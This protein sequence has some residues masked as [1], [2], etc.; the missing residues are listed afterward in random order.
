[1]KDLAA[2]VLDTILAF[3]IAR[4]NQPVDQPRQIVLR[5]QHPF[6][7]L[8]GA[9]ARCT[10]APEFQQ[11]IIP[12]ERRKALRLQIGLDPSQQGLRNADEP[13]PG[14]DGFFRKFVCIAAHDPS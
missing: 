8:I 14:G 5:Q 6:L 12:G 1:M 4:L 10:G 7:K 2:P 11:R 9:Q 3:D 13:G